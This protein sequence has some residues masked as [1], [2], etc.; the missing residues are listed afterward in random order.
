[1]NSNLALSIVF[2]VSFIC[3]VKETDG[4]KCY[5]CR[6]CKDPFDPKG[7]NTTRC[8]GSSCVKVKYSGNKVSRY[9][10]DTQIDDTCATLHPQDGS[11]YEGCVCNNDLCNG[12]SVQGLSVMLS[13]IIFVAMFFKAMY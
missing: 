13:V 3:L 1:M 5:L 2:A 7:V 6:D 8:I 12:G 4:L 9:C 11:S 10:I